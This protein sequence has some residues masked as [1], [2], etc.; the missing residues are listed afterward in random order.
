[1]PVATLTE[2][3]RTDAA[4]PSTPVLE[5]GRNCWRIEHAK[6]LAF[7]VDGENYFRAVREAVR[8]AQ[9]SVFVLGWDVD[10]R[11]R[12]VPEGANDGWPEQFADF[13]DAL[14]R[15]RKGLRA[16]VLSWDFAMLYM[17]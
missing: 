7:L 2:A 12:L 17:L 13:L 3:P 5:P 16:Y 10:S 4:E 11:M 14:V 9:H 6:R 1:L 8:E 15:E